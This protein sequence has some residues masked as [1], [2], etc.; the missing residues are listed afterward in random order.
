MLSRQKLYLLRK[1]LGLA[2]HVQ[3]DIFEAGAGSGGSAKLMMDYLV[4]VRSR[5]AFW[6][7]DA[8]RDGAHME[9]NQCLCKSA[10]EVRGLLANQAL[11][12]HVVKGLI[13]E[14]LN[15][16][17][18]EKISFVRLLREAN[19]RVVDMAPAMEKTGKPLAYYFTSDPHWNTRGHALAA[20]LLLGAQTASPLVPRP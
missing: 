9:L 3:G 14:T 4:E 13:P 8:F 18:A 7:L 11:A 20:E 5:K 12:V 17:Q 10:D 2:A 15:D 16:V 19:L 6:V 1:L